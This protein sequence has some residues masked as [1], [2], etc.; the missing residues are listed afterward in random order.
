M[1]DNDPR[2]LVNSRKTSYLLVSRD[3]THLGIFEGNLGIKKSYRWF[4]IESR[5]WKFRVADPSEISAFSFQSRRL[6]SLTD[7]RRA[8]EKAVHTATGARLVQYVWFKGHHTYKEIVLRRFSMRYLSS[9]M[10]TDIKF[11]K[12]R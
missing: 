2:T 6:S 12:L 11:Q 3:W 8:G 4:R 5:R 10:T 9:A 1:D 7:K